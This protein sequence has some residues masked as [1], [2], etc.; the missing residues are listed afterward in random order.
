MFI[1]LI[2]PKFILVPA[3]SKTLIIAIQVS[4]N[5]MCENKQ[6]GTKMVKHV[7]RR[8]KKKVI[9]SLLYYAPSNF[10]FFCSIWAFL[11]TD[12]SV[13]EEPLEKKMKE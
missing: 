7:T 4:L 12:D 11:S 2:Q 9:N 3:I 8:R 10:F 6:H 1:K 13:C 5:S